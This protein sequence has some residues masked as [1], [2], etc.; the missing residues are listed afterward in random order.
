MFA[1][2]LRD[3]LPRYVS[4]CSE[5]GMIGSAVGRCLFFCNVESLQLTRVYIRT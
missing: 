5:S 1:W 3:A 4:R 2:M